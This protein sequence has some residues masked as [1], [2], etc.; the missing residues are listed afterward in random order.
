MA[1][2]A[3]GA[4]A[5]K[6]NLRA[7]IRARRSAIDPVVLA[8][9]DDD[10]ARTAQA[11]ILNLPAGARV[12]CYLSSPTEPGTNALVRALI[13]GG[14]EVIAPRVRGRD[15]DWA[16][17]SAASTFVTGSFGIRE[18]SGPSVGQGA[19]PLRS[20]GLVFVPALAID[21]RGV[22]LGQGG[23][24][25]DRTLE[26]L[27]TGPAAGPLLVGV[28]NQDELYDEL[29]AEDYDR[30]VAAALSPAAITYLPTAAG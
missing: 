26:Q 14:F 8:A 6:A 7:Q 20:A 24:F 29:P 9:R 12:A 21:H 1:P 13:T 15:L 17:A 28:I 23:G 3:D 5:A 4:S 27:A 2:F 16:V 19:E 25:Y 22:R 10:L 11:L 30:V 18:V